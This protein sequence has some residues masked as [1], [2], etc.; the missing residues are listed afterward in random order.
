M[1]NRYTDSEREE[2]EQSAYEMSGK[3]GMSAELGFEVARSLFDFK[4]LL[5]GIGALILAIVVIGTFIYGAIED[6]GDKIEHEIHVCGENV[7]MGSEHAGKIDIDK[8]TITYS[9]SICGGEALV[10]GVKERV[11]LGEPEISNGCIGVY[12]HLEKWIWEAEGQSLEREVS[13]YTDGEIVHSDPYVLNEGWARTC[14]E[15]GMTDELCCRD[16]NEVFQLAT[17]I[18]KGHDTYT[19]GAYDADCTR[20]GYTGDSYCHGCDYFEPG[21]FTEIGEHKYA[22][23][24]D[25]IPTCNREGYTGDMECEVCHEIGEYGEAI[26]EVD[27][28]YIYYG[29]NPNTGK[30][31]YICVYCGRD[32]FRDSES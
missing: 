5:G 25:R 18:P 30:H 24:Y 21:G 14:T 13:V 15:D 10:V 9:C 4:K 2:I 19:V 3:H 1:G 7:A 20:E 6:I 32:E 29:V 11:T 26:P 12:H 27:H 31:T 23:L 8:G 16:C 17:V 28:S 22:L